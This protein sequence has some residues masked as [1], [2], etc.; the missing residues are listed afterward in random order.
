MNP[1][2][3]VMQRVE[4]FLNHCGFITACDIPCMLIIVISGT[5]E[6]IVLT[7]LIHSFILKLYDYVTE[8]I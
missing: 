3:E 8:H 4:L 1:V 5:S 2:I 6:M 7:Y